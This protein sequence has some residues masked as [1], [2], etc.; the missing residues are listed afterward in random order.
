LNSIIDGD[1]AVISGVEDGCVICYNDGRMKLSASTAAW[2]SG[3]YV[4]VLVGMYRPIQRK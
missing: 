1:I 4:G 2:T 3:D